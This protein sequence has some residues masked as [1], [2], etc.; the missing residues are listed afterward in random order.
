MWQLSWITIQNLGCPDSRGIRHMGHTVSLYDPL[1]FQLP[2]FLL[3][4]SFSTLWSKPRGVVGHFSH[5]HNRPWAKCTDEVHPL[6]AELV[7]RLQLS[8]IIL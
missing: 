6:L 3:N 4:F 8:F 2:I 7:G 5:P 1:V